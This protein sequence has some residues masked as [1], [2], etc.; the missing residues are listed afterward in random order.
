MSDDPSDQFPPDD[1]EPNEVERNR[2]ARDRLNKRMID[3]GN[4]FTFDVR[5]AHITGLTEALLIQAIMGEVADLQD[6]DWIFCSIE[7]LL[8]DWHFSARDQYHHLRRLER[9]GFIQCEYFGPSTNRKRRIQINKK[10]IDDALETVVL[11]PLDH[12]QEDY[13]DAV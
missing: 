3:S 10:I 8:H 12:D 11:P 6:G 5:F 1:E 9:Q 13:D 4:Y 7:H 2:Q